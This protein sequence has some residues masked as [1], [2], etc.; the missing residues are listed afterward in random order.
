MA[1]A[2]ASPVLLC[3]QCNEQPLNRRELSPTNPPGSEHRNK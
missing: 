2:I 1:G 3:L